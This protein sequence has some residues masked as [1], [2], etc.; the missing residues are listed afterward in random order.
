M[1][2][3]SEDPV[4]HAVRPET[5]AVYD[6]TGQRV[7]SPKQRRVVIQFQRGHAP[8]WV[9]EVA[10][11]S[12]D[13]RKRPVE[14]P[15]ETWVSWYDSDEDQQA[16]GWTDEEKHAIEEYLCTAFGTLRVE[17]PQQPKP[18]EAITKLT[19][20]K[21]RTAEQVAADMARIA[22]EVGVPL[23][24]V[25]AYVA[26]NTGKY[27]WGQPLLDELDLHVATAAPED[28]GELVVA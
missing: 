3:I 9:R 22:D 16:H 24:T 1:M 12:F 28:D 14:I 19:V 7:V 27:G 25:V 23:S 15:P 5:P 20:T 6:Q 18:W 21:A 11:A 17:Q 8:L 2:F 26:A 10:L 4:Q 13:F